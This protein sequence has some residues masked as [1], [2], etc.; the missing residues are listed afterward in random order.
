MRTI[1]VND[2]REGP[3][4]MVWAFCLRNEHLQA[5]CVNATDTIRVYKPAS[6]LLLFESLQMLEQ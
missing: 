5:E 3:G 2:T 6:H 1:R 4:E